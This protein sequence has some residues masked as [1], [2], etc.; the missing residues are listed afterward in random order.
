M[1]VSL[2]QVAMVLFMITSPII[3]KKC[4]QVI[5]LG[6]LGLLSIPFMMFIAN[7]KA[8]GNGGVVVVGLA[9]FMRS[10][11]MNAANPIMNS[12]P[13]EFVSKELRP[14]YNSAIFVAGSLT[15][16]VAGYF[17]KGF[18]FKTNNGYNVAYYITAVIYTIASVII[19]V[20]YKKKY[21]RSH[22]TTEVVEEQAS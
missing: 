14:A 19:I 9:L 7:G 20:V 12:L 11:L 18:L 10:G 17:T 5:S 4:G 8:F 6:G 13:M 2:Q 3:T 15:S 1:L 21:N 16:T 22:E